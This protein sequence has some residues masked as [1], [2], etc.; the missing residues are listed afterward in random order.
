MKQSNNIPLGIALMI[1]VTFVFAVQDGLS[2]HLAG[3]YNVLMIVMIRYWFFA[4][5][6]IA[7]AKRHAKGIR[8]VARTDQ[9]WVQIGRGLLL[10]TEICVMVVAFTILG[11]V[12]SHAVFTCYPLLVA[13]FSGPV[14]GEHVGWRRWAAIAVG[15]IGVVIILRPSGDVFDIR[16]LIPLLA[17]TM[18]AVYGLLTRFASRRD[19]STTSF[20]W[21]GVVGAVAMTSVGVWFWEPMSGQDWIWMTCLCFTGVTGHWLLIRCYEV[22]EASAVQPFAYLQLVFAA[23]IGISAFGETVSTNVAIGCVIIVAAGLFT[24]WR[25]RL[26]R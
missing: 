2:R 18:F 12:E 19:S 8:G 10:A 9:P 16:A 7:L 22:A 4:A 3:E 20:F 6:V 24:F 23:V 25:E 21:T 14:L 26:Q 1:A 17:A 13:A 11:L 15:F 5:F